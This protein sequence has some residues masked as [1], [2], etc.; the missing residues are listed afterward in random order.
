MG[1]P[2]KL[3]L[4]NPEFTWLRVPAVVAAWLEFF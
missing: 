3:G 4:P 1:T 2:N